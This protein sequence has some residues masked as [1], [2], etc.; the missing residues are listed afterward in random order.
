[1]FLAVWA[2]RD[3]YQGRNRFRSYLVAV[4]LHRCQFVARQARCRERKLGDLAAEGATHPPLNNGAMQALIEAERRRQVREKLTQLPDNM[5]EVLILRF[6][7]GL[8]L[9]EI[10]ALTGLSE[11]TVKSHL[12]R[13]VRRLHRW[14]EADGA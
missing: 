4:T 9:E 3:E 5:R 6:T 14:L 12:F 8:P 11:G 10:A 2:E 7:H 1:V 13:G